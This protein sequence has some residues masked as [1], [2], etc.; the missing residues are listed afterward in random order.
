MHPLHNRIIVEPI[1]EEEK[2][3]NG[4]VLLED[5]TYAKG[6]VIATGNGLQSEKMELEVGDIAVYHKRDAL[7]VFGKTVLNQSQVIMF[8]EEPANEVND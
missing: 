7:L 4:V 6:R 8:E 2:I 1:K 5:N 3:S